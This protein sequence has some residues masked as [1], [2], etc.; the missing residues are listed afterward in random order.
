MSMEKLFGQAVFSVGDKGYAWED[1]LLAA[2]VRGDWADLENELRQGLAC[3]RCAEATHYAIPVQQVTAAA[4]EFRYKRSLITAEE[5]ETWLK[6]WRLSVEDW[7]GYVRRS[8]LRKLWADD[9]PGIVASYALSEDEIKTSI[10]AEAICSGS[11]ARFAR[12]L[13]GSAAA[14]EKLKELSE[15]A[16]SRDRIEAGLEALLKN[17]DSYEMENLSRESLY[18]KLK[19]LA[20]LETAFD[21]LAGQCITPDA[22]RS[23]V[24]ANRID[25]I[26]LTVDYVKFA[27]EPA[28]REGA[29][30]IREDQMT[31]AEV[32]AEAQQPLRHTTLFID[33]LSGD[34]KS[35]FLGCAEGELLGPV[36]WE[37]QLALCWVVAKTMPDEAEPQIRKKAEQNILDTLVKREINDRVRWR[38][39][40][41]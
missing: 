24:A 8:L 20:V 18:E 9:L 40:L 7:M 34:L 11:L 10:Q 2:K 41:E 27:G 38:V 4:N 39:A 25:W 12:S 6:Q 19:D 32:A 23:C 5:T 28:A 22:A 36:Q 3:L 17:V 13:A 1:V 21:E 29:L 14:Y 37:G 30:C 31:L 16:I 33:E 35:E 15:I 26:K